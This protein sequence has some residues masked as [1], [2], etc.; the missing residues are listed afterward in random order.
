MSSDQQIHSANLHFNAHGTPV[1][2]DFDDVYFS[3][4]DGLAESQYVFLAANKLPSRWRAHSCNSFTIAETGFGTGLNF[5]ASWQAFDDYLS[6]GSANGAQQLHF[7]SFEKFPL[8]TTDLAAA[9][10]HFPN[11]TR[12]ARQLQRQFPTEFRRGCHRLTFAEGRVVLDLWLGDINEVMPTL[13]NNTGGIVDAWFLDGFAPSKNPQM[14]QQSLFDQ[15]FRLSRAGASVATF[16]AAGL[17]RRGLAQAGF[18]V[19]KQPGYGNKRDMTIANREP[20]RVSRPD[21]TD[22]TVA[23]IGGGLA[24]CLTA[25]KLANAGKQVVLLCADQ[26]LA[27]A[28]SGNRQGALYPLLTPNPGELSQF[29]WQ[30]FDLACNDYQQLT[31]KTDRIR[32]Q[33]CGLLHL[34]SNE[35]LSRKHSAIASH[36]YP[37]TLIQLVDANRASELA[38][39]D[40]PHSAAYYPNAGW[41]CP[42]DICRFIG[43]WLI[44]NG[45]DVRFDWRVDDISRDNGYWQLQGKQS[46]KAKQVVIAAGIDSNGFDVSRHLPISSVRGQVSHV[47]VTE[48]SSRLKTVICHTGYL[49]PSDHDAWDGHCMGA[50]FSRDNNS[51]ELL[52]EDHQI[53]LERLQQALPES[54]LPQDWKNSATDGRV[55][56]R[57]VLR[58]HFPV[59]GPIPDWSSVT[60]LPQTTQLSELPHQAGLY[61]I[62]GLGARGICSGPL[63]AD[64]IT[65]YICDTA[66]PTSQA[67]LD[68]VNPG[69]FVW[70]RLKK[71]RPLFD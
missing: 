9:H 33:W 53:N 40:I 20:N 32:H 46:I 11:L 47:P 64:I 60:K 7:I 70:R 59:V 37:S 42:G 58:D 2:E 61:V 52:D 68:A 71:N 1:A 5:L 13:P 24:A 6:Q 27:L 48:Q 3:N 26:Q 14:W 12:Y 65:S 21:T 17:V 51:T 22:Q 8:T 15:M 29:Y 45:H 30:A 54:A 43:D 63:A 69:R 66:H 23:I 34:N 56:F 35:E 50:T 44:D 10:A 55:G 4:D 25:W 67:L 49:T 28:A 18:T 36:N 62:S 31:A 38:G 39:I 41:F 16:T 19:A 57:A